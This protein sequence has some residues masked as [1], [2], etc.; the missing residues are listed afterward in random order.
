MRKVLILLALLMLGHTALAD[1]ANSIRNYVEALE[2]CL[3]D[4]KFADAGLPNFWSEFLGGDYDLLARSDA[5]YGDYIAC[6]RKDGASPIPETAQLRSSGEFSSSDYTRTWSLTDG[7]EVIYEF[8]LGGNM[9]LAA[10]D[11]FTHL[12]ILIHDYEVEPFAEGAHPI[13]GAADSQRRAQMANQAEM[14]FTLRDESRP[15]LAIEVHDIST[16]RA[17]TTDQPTAFYLNADDLPALTG[18]RWIPEEDYANLVR[19]PLGVYLLRDGE[20][21]SLV[22]SD[23]GIRGVEVN[24]RLYEAGPGFDAALELAEQALGYRPGDLDFP[25]KTAVRATLEW[26]DG[27]IAFDGHTEVWQS[28]SVSE[29]DEAT[30]RRIDALLN[31]ADFS[32]GS[33]NCPSDCFLTVEYGDGTSCSLAVATNSFDTLFYRGVCFS[34]DEMLTNLFPMRDTDF[35]RAN[36]G[37]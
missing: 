35:Y 29:G 2:A 20:S 4:A 23:S 19:I 18:E 10:F 15:Q 32:I 1:S 11:N 33:V 25:G 6:V 16:W 26:Q 36:F 30:L 7:G 5:K 31:G 3:P 8:V 37:G 22:I 13:L 12:I 28:G 21:A 14:G 17:G 27:E 34:V 24:D 9:E